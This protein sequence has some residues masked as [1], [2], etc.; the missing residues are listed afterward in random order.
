MR[1]LLIASAFLCLTTVANAAEEPAQI[2][3]A[4]PSLTG[5]DVP[6]SA[7][8]G[9]GPAAPFSEPVTEG[10]VFTGGVY[11]AGVG[12]DPECGRFRHRCRQC[13]AKCMFCCNGTC[14]MYQH[15]PYRAPFQ[16]YYYFRPYNY[17]MVPKQQQEVL[18]LG[19]D[20]RNPYSV[21]MFEPIYKDFYA[22]VPPLKVPEGS[23]LPLGDGLPLLEDLLNKK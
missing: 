21:K 5:T 22:R 6:L 15:F 4:E 16:N 7:P 12:Y 20:T 14:D 9:I 17:I 10:E 8:A 19:G 1:T 13:H 18:R 2:P 23:A 11:D 3:S